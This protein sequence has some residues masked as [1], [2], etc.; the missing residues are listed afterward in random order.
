MTMEK[1]T[2][3][4]RDGDFVISGDDVR[5]A[6][7]DA[8]HNGEIYG[9]H[10]LTEITDIIEELNNSGVLMVNLKTDRPLTWR[11]KYYD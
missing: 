8:V 11:Q 9:P 7:I 3:A 6:Y 5:I 10:D 1:Y 2:V 4:G